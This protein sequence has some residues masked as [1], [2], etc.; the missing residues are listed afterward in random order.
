MGEKAEAKAKAEHKEREAWRVQ[1]QV[2]FVTPD[3]DPLGGQV[4]PEG[5]QVYDMTANDGEEEDQEEDQLAVPEPNARRSVSGML[6]NGAIGTAGLAARVAYH[7]VL[8]PGWWAGNKFM[9]FVIDN[10][11]S[12]DWSNPGR[13]SALDALMGFD[14][15]FSFVGSSSSG[16]DG[17][18]SSEDLRRPAPRIPEPGSRTPDVGPGDTQDKE[19]VDRVPHNMYYGWVGETDP[20]VPKN[21]RL[22][23]YGR[24]MLGVYSGRRLDPDRPGRV[25]TETHH[26]WGTGYE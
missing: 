25:R 18:G 11:R 6:M 7:G 16:D 26:W 4:V 21:N 13:R 24:R 3:A 12:N 14:P 9:D 19:I 10:Q 1:I 15:R 22:V 23:Q 5:P 8:R 20:T 2:I 17:Y